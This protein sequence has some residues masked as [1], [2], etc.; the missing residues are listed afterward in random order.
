M[1]VMTQWDS[2]GMYCRGMAQLEVLCTCFLMYLGLRALFFSTS[3]AY[4][5]LHRYS[6]AA[7]VGCVRSGA[8]RG[9]LRLPAGSEYQCAVVEMGVQVA[10][11]IESFHSARAAAGVLQ[12]QQAQ[13]F[14][15]PLT[16]TAPQRRP[17]GTEQSSTAEVSA[18]SE[19]HLSG[20]SLERDLPAHINLPAPACCPF[21]HQLLVEMVR[22]RRD[23]LNA[24][25][26]GEPQIDHE[27]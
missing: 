13:T 27:P 9:S 25:S 7:G 21:R 18:L 12:A 3:R 16:W 5:T 2:R 1:N 4:F 24:W 22:W 26:W 10:E 17:D 23:N 19:G 15:S 14:P 11:L 20:C 6:S 8:D